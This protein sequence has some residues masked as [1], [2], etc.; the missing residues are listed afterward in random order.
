MTAAPLARINPSAESAS[1]LLI[2]RRIAERLFDK[3]FIEVVTGE[4]NAYFLIEE[5]GRGTYGGVFTASNDATRIPTF[6]V[7]SFDLREPGLN[8]LKIID[9]NS[10]AEQSVSFADEIDNER[11]YLFNEYVEREYRIARLLNVAIDSNACDAS[12]VCAREIIY[13][14]D[15]RIGYIVF[16][17]IPAISL[18]QYIVLYLNNVTQKTDRE[19]RAIDLRNATINELL[20]FE[21][22]VEPT[23]AADVQRMIK[24]VLK[25]WREIFNISRQ[26]LEAVG[27]LHA[28]GF[29]HG[30]LKPTNIIMQGSTLKVID[31][32]LACAPYADT[33]PGGVFFPCWTE[34]RTAPIYTDPLAYQPF[35]GRL[36][37]D[38]VSKDYSRYEIYSVAKIIQ[39]LSTPNLF[40]ENGALQRDI[41]IE[42]NIFLAP[43]LHELLVRMTGEVGERRVTAA[44]P[45]LTR[46]QLNARKES[47][48]ERPSA[49]EVLADLIEI[50]NH[51]RNSFTDAYVNA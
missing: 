31:F 41:V 15:R 7:K 38:I 14:S 33:K 35:D 3:E 17:Y 13:S 11:Y 6:A 45:R 36:T 48:E 44:A 21:T 42:K 18:T 4:E 26:L 39:A 32:G 46:P 40:K 49:A 22:L 30:D 23:R 1:E 2:R 43:G 5:L 28:N 47:F 10:L 16:P 37:P 19:L 27:K 24:T 25:V 8:D 20:T 50:D 29:I 51:W 34:F 9:R 12:F